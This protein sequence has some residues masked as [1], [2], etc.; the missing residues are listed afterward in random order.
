MSE[1]PATASHSAARAVHDAV[2]EAFGLEVE[3][4]LRA[5]AL[6][7]DG[8][9]ADA[10]ALVHATG[11]P[12]IHAR[13]LLEIAAPAL[14]DPA[15]L[16]AL[17]REAGVPAEPFDLLTLAA[18][19][20][21]E[22][23]PAEALQAMQAIIEAVPAPRAE[24]DHIAATPRTL[25]D[26]ASLLQA[27]YGRAAPRM[28]FL[29]D[30]DCSALACREVIAAADATVADLDAGLLAHIEQ[31]SSGAVKTAFGDFRLGL[32]RSLT[33]GFD[34]VFTDPPYT[35][36]G[37]ELFLARA[38]EALDP[39]ADGRIL[40]A[41]GYSRKHPGL[42]QKVQES[43]SRLRLTLEAML[44]G[45]NRYLAAPAIGAQADLYI[46]RP[47]SRSAPAAERL[48]GQARIYTHGRSAGEAE[49]EDL[50]EAIADFARERAPEAVALD[51]EEHLPRLLS[52]DAAA[53]RRS[54]KQAGSVLLRLHPHFED[55]A[56]HAVLFG[57]AE[58]ILLVSDKG[59]PLLREFRQDAGDE[60]PVLSRFYRLDGWSREAGRLVCLDL[61]R[62][63]PDEEV[64]EVLAELLGRRSGKLANAWRKTLE[65]RASGRSKNELR[66]L[67]ADTPNGAARGERHVSEFPPHAISDLFRDVEIT[68]RAL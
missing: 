32:P 35:P 51:A 4:A 41:Y 27:A 34:L 65:R 24:L 66:A 26:R 68:V 3:G 25:W 1:S 30:H 49:A 42:G 67:I 10:D 60:P 18:G 22:T 23:A 43:F 56:F 19:I 62:I 16:S 40:L 36:E 12:F 63:A 39:Q 46:L 15:A 29:G 52:E 59:N 9:I 54:P 37:V 31:A 53:L 28:L 58:Q 33:G 17:L 57:V 21:A 6:V 47:T 7:A 11:L 50:P 48:R 64:D 38:I 44:P 13:R 45:F 61:R 14:D 20:R 8:G 2:L 55:M 5:L